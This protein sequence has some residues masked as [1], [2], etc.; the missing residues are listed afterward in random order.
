MMDVRVSRVQPGRGLSGLFLPHRVT[1]QFDH[2]GIVDDAVED[3]VGEGG[4]IQIRV[5]LRDG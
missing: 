2:V 5:P 4:I 1:A 3:R